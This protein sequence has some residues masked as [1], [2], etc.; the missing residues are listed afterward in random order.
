MRFNILLAEDNRNYQVRFRNN[1]SK[2]SDLEYTL[3]STPEELFEELNSEIDLIILRFGFE[4]S[5]VFD[6]FSIMKEFRLNYPDLQVIIVDE[7][8]DSTKYFNCF[9]TGAYDCVAY[10]SQD[11]LESIDELIFRLQK[12][13]IMKIQSLN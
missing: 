9:A 2:K 8:F 13:K 4:D 10:E 11:F 3:C 7:S 6:T 1:F 12:K 5:M